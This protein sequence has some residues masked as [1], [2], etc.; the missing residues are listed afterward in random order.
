M[1]TEGRNQSQK[2]SSRLYSRL[3]CTW[4]VESAWYSVHFPP[5]SA[6]SPRSRPTFLCWPQ[7]ANNLMWG[8]E[9]LVLWWPAQQLP[10]LV[11]SSFTPPFPTPPHASSTNT[12]AGL[13][14]EYSC[15]NT[16]VKSRRFTL[17]NGKPTP[18]DVVVRKM[19]ICAS[20]GYVRTFNFQIRNPIGDSCNSVFSLSTVSVVEARE[21][22]LHSGWGNVPLTLVGL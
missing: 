22:V 17:S 15:E 8:L 16:T 13:H 21:A 7:T 12:P 19:Y 14:W 18:L 4:T 5:P 6:A 2:K 3:W 9:M 10:W 20:V 11:S 1:R